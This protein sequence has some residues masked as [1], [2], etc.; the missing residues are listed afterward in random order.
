MSTGRRTQ[1][2]DGLATSIA[3]RL[4]KFGSKAIAVHVQ[5]ARVRG[6]TRDLSR[7]LRNLPDNAYEHAA[8]NVEL[9]LQT[10][11]GSAEVMVTDDGEGIPEHHRSAVFER[12]TRLDD[13]RTRARTGGGFGLGLAIAR[14]IAVAHGGT[15]TA[16]PHPDG[17]SG[18]MFLLRLPLSDD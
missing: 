10:A 13:S 9:V 4:R 16:H 12:F 2:E 1:E 11:A 8:W 7:L 18:A 14:Q 5:A 6:S 3:R 17:A 15:L